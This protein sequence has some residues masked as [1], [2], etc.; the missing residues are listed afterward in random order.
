MNSGFGTPSSK[1]R[2]SK[3]AN[4]PNPVRSMRLR[5][6]FGIIWSVSTLTRF[7]GATNP[8]SDV[9]FSMCQSSL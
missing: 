6:C 9:N 3:N 7:R 4:S 5:N 8:V 2:Q 1:Y